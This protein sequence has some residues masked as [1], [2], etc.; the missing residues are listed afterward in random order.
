MVKTFARAIHNR[1]VVEFT[2]DGH[3]RIV[4]PHCLGISTRGRHVLRAYQTG[5]TSSTG[6]VPDWRLF[7]VEKISTARA[8]GM[9]FS[10]PRPDY[11]PN[12]SSMTAVIAAL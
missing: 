4:E 1:L 9:T 7:A 10:T 6:S 12:D 8:T 11:T 2:Y 3:R 5:G